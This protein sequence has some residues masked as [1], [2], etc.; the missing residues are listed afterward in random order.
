M[1]CAEGRNRWWA[2]PELYMLEA[3]YIEH[4]NFPYIV[5]STTRNIVDSRPCHAV[6]GFSLW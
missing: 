5:L 4:A 2:N 1:D 3:L 6:S